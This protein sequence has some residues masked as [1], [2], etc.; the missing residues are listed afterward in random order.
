MENIYKEVKRVNADKAFGL[1]EEV[2]A[3]RME[4][5]LSNID[6]SAPSHSEADIIPKNVFTLFNFINVII[7]LALLYTGSYKNLMFMGV[8]ICNCIIGIVQ[9]LRAKKALDKLS[10]INES[11]IS[12]V[13]GGKN[14]KIKPK[15]LVLDDIVK[16]ESGAQVVADSSI[17][18]GSCEV[19][20][21]LLTGEPDL[22]YK[23]EKDALFSGSFVAGGSCYARVERVGDKNYVSEIYNGAKY[24]KENNSEIMNFLKKLIKI[25]SFAIIPIGALLFFNQLKIFSYDLNAAVAGTASALIG[26]IPEGLVLLTSTALAVS[27]LKLSKQNVLVRDLYCIETL[28]KADTLCLDK[29]GTITEGTLEV[30]NI[31][32][33]EGFN[34]CDVENIMSMLVSVL[35]DS[36]ETFNALKRRFEKSQALVFS[37]MLK[38]DKEFQEVI[39]FSS[40]RKWSGVSLKKD[41]SYIIGAAEVIFKDTYENL[42]ENIKKFSL[43]YRV[44]VLAKSES[45]FINRELPDKIIPV[46][47]ILLKDKIKE[48]AK[49][50]F[51]FFKQNEVDIKVISGDNPITVSSI[52]KDAGIKHYEAYID[53]S[54]IKEGENLDEISQK[55]KIFGRVSPLQKRDLIK[56][57]KNQG[58]TVAMTGDGVND[59]LALKEADCSIA[60]ANGSEAARSVAQIVLLDSEFSSMSSIVSE[61]QRVINNI[62]RASTL[63]LAKTIYSFALAV[64]FLLIKAPYPFIPI[65]MTLISSLTIGIP[66]FIL[67]LEANAEKIK[68]SF[69]KNILKHSIPTSVS[70]ILNIILCIL[71]YKLLGLSYRQYST[72]C[73]L[74]TGVL[75]IALIYEISYPLNLKRKILIGAV[76]GA[77]IV[78]LIFLKKLF[79]VAP[80][81]F[82][83]IILLV[84]IVALDVLLKKFIKRL[85]LHGLSTQ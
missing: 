70:I 60:I 63:F 52:A 48:T 49:S 78:A 80:L 17:I 53:M 14:I 31:V 30:T 5:N 10:L 71:S 21:A 22:I 66:S 64:L 50:S 62:Q 68:Q 32:P 76:S 20:E 47:L 75:E 57:L 24:V 73:V 38:L 2:V 83:E 12:V 77:F 4:Q 33:Q 7:A 9:E 29:T 42:K 74:L 3:L 79:S 19:N 82:I 36:N 56:S 35:K 26:M 43:D 59:V 18:E 34:Q 54:Q 39:P 65:Q 69:I 61:G 41:E 58:H 16:Y 81:S 45:C 40:A 13:R 28:A 15:N 27:V 67:A 25:I 51:E 37:D 46:S 84:T 1:S 8:V 6:T 72:L 44:L 11:M 23:K 55:Y 85:V